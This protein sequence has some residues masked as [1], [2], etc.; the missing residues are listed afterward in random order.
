MHA[1]ANEHLDRFQIDAPGLAAV[2]KDFLCQTFY[3][4][5]GFLL[6][7]FDSFF[8]CSGSVSCSNGRK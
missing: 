7:R 2:G 6:D 5:S 1:L 8:S 4:A 3:F